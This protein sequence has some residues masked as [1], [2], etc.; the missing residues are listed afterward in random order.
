MF[1]LVYWLIGAV[2]D[3]RLIAAVMTVSTV[4]AITAIT[5]TASIHFRAIIVIMIMTT[6][7]RISHASMNMLVSAKACIS[8]ET[9]AVTMMTIAVTVAITVDYIEIGVKLDILVVVQHDS[10]TKIR[11]VDFND[12]KSRKAIRHI[13]GDLSRYNAVGYHSVYG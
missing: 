3:I 11:F 8:C 4:M 7:T 2:K 10:P 13:S 9:V 1:Q 5:I 12:V 6:V